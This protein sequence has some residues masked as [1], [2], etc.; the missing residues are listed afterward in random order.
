MER[1]SA[2]RAKFKK[3][4]FSPQSKLL[5]HGDRVQQ[6][7]KTHHTTPVLMELSP[8]GYC[9]ADC[10]W[11]FFKDKQMHER[12][13]SKTMLDFIKQIAYFDIKAINWTG[14]GEPTLHPSFDDFVKLAYDLDI[15]QGIFTNGYKELHYPRMFDW[16]RIS[17]TPKGYDAIVKP[18]APFGICLNQTKEHT[19]DELHDLCIKARAFGASYFQVRPALEGSYRKQPYIKAP[20]FLQEYET[21]LFRVYVTDY[22]YNEAR[23]KHHYDKCY[24][25]HLCP[26]LDWQGN[27][28][29]CLYR[30]NEPKYVLGNI[31]KDAFRKILCEFPKYAAVTGKCQNCCKNNEINKAMYFA[32]TVKDV[33]FL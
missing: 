27:V 11:C 1:G 17:L 4:S 18:E 16:I 32:K 5:W 21:E 15:K 22:K 9:N 12:I 24:G 23:E 10:P 7:L 14:G 33:D 26:G 8:T 13:D 28:V 3:T 31:Y 29:V 20:L 25:Y 19:D 6:W 30:Q 2:L